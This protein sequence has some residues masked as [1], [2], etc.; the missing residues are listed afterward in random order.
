MKSLGVLKQGLLNLTSKMKNNDKQVE[1]SEKILSLIKD[2]RKQSVV[3]PRN[4]MI[5][6]FS[7]HSARHLPDS[8]NESLSGINFRPENHKIKG[9]KNNNDADEFSKNQPSTPHTIRSLSKK[10]LNWK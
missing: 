8:D 7:N 10:T 1:T 5:G 9:C 2:R 6:L 4:S 3:L